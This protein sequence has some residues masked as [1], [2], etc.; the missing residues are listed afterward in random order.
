M[1]YSGEH[2][3]HVA[4]GG[5]RVTHRFLFLKRPASFGHMQEAAYDITLQQEY[6]SIKYRTDTC[7]YTRQYEFITL[8]SARILLRKQHF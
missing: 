5:W 2:T 7:V 1:P 3:S 6:C 8:H 4:R